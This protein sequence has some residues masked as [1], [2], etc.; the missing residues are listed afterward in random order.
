M[1]AEEMITYCGVHGGTCARWHEAATMRKLAAALA[2]IAD[3]HGFHHWMPGAVKEFDYAAFRKGLEFF[4]R[5]DTW[6]LC[7]KC[8]RDGGGH[9]CRI[10]DCCRGRGVELCFECSDFP[11]ALVKDHTSMM[12]RAREYKRLG[13]E[14]WLR[15]QIELAEQG[16]EHHTGKCYQVSRGDP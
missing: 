16:F 15:W 9:P 12:E 2:E 3:G 5:D 7:R 10:Q 14:A 13:R 6:L 4:A 8:C 1:K 11:C